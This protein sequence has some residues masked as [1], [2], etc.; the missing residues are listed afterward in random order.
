M[1][2]AVNAVLFV[3][4]QDRFGVAVGLV[5]VAAGFEPLDAERFYDASAELWA[6]IG[7]DL[8]GDSSCRSCRHT[9]ARRRDRASAA[10]LYYELGDPQ[11]DR[12]DTLASDCPSRAQAG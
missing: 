1:L 3:Q 12:R 2:D 6:P 7:Y 9:G 8:K 11:S 10:S 4:M 5:N